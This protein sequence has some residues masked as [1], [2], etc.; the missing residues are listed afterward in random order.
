VTEEVAKLV[1]EIRL[2][3]S[4]IKS[5]VVDFRSVY[6]LQLMPIE[7]SGT[8]HF[9]SPDMFRSEAI[10][11]GREIIT[12]R[13][14][15]MVHRYLPR[16]KEIWTY[17]LNDLPQTEPMNFAVADLRDPFFAVD[18]LSLEYQG[19][20]DASG[21][22]T[23]AFTADIK[24]WAKQGVLD[25]RKGF[26]LQYRPKGVEYQLRLH[27][28]VETGLLRRMTGTDKTGKLILQ[29]DYVIESTNA[30]LSESM[31]AVDESTAEYRSIEISDIFLSSMNP[32]A[33][34]DP[35]SVN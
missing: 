11:N 30:E 33:A 27:I 9:L 1:R 12:I 35:P 15:S 29:T 18:E 2:Q 16:K 10:V 4:R 34:E 20:Q 6:S 31:C 23:H 5:L 8:F 25:T 32:N 26:S 13:K 21:T 28:D 3:A 22:S 7:A 19:I 14:G 17:N 24:N